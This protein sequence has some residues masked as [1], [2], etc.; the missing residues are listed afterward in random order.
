MVRVPLDLGVEVADGGVLGAQELV[1]VVQVPPSLRDRPRSIVVEP[2]VL[3]AAHDMPG[4]E[5]LIP[6]A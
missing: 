6:R 2:P 3:V 4:P 5:R 1:R